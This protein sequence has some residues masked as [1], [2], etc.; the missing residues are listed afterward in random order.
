M[1]RAELLAKMDSREITEWQAYFALEHERI[2]A[3]R[4]RA[5]MNRGR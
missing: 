3:D 2:E 1:T 4:E 5:K